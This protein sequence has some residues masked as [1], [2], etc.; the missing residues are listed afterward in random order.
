[1]IKLL[2]K[3]FTGGGIAA[4]GEQINDWQKVKLEAANDKD[5]IEAELAIER[6]RE[7][8]QVQMEG[9]HWAP[10]LVRAILISPV[11]FY[12]GKILTYDKLGYGT[13][14]NLTDTQW[15]IVGIMIGF[16]FLSEVNILKR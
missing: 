12:W 1:M 6:L 5:R 8:R 3:W 16:Y 4:I 13:T 14:D 9:G 7:Q 10:R 2:L 15:Y 11:A